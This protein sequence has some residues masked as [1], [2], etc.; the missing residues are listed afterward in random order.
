MFSVIILSHTPTKLSNDG[1]LMY[2][3]LC[4]HLPAKMIHVSFL[5]FSGL[6]SFGKQVT[7]FANCEEEKGR[8][9]GKKAINNQRAYV[10]YGQK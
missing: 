5:F 10:A 2:A 1:A 8:E 9:R 6:D 3:N 7:T 4:C